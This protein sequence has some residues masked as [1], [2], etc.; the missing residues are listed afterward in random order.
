MRPR[1][2]ASRAVAFDYL[3]LFNPDSIV[4]EAERVFPGKGLELTNLW[5]N[6]Q[7]EYAWLRSITNRYVDF[8]AVTEDALVHAGKF[9]VRPDQIVSDLNGLL[10]IVSK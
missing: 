2:R 10:D 6:R 4:P 7:F 5:R 8:S 1:G 3:V 9:G